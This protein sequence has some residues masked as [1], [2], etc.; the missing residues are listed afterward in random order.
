MGDGCQVALDNQSF[1]FNNIQMPS[2]TPIQFIGKGA[3][4]SLACHL[5]SNIKKM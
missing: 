2:I 4:S 5:F 3:C 1:L